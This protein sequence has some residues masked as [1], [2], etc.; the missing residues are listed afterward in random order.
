MDTGTGC[1]CIVCRELS[2]FHTTTGVDDLVTL[3]EMAHELSP[4]VREI[5]VAQT[6]VRKETASDHEK[7]I[8]RQAAARCTA[9]ALFRRVGELS[10]KVVH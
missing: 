7:E 9:G 5:M 10:P 1:D 4:D 6:R 2:T 8:V 3:M